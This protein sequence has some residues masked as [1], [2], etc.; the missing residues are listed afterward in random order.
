[1]SWREIT[2]GGGRVSCTLEEGAENEI[3]AESEAEVEDE[4]ASEEEEV[5]TV[6][7][8]GA[9]VNDGGGGGGVNEAEGGVV[10]RARHETNRGVAWSV[11]LP[12]SIPSFH[13]SAICVFNMCSITGN[14]P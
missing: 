11:F 3:G 10:G 2:V 7:L 9:E 8:E 6:A 14:A 1:M 13:K 12:V 4:V 5:E